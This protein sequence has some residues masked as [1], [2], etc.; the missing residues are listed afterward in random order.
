MDIENCLNSILMNVNADDLLD[1]YAV[2]SL[3]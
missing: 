1:L 2:V 3:S